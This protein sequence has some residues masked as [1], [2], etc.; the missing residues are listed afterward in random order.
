MDDPILDLLLLVH[1]GVQSARLA[2]DTALVEQLESYLPPLVAF[3]EKW[4]VAEN[5][6]QREQL[7]LEALAVFAK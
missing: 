5:N 2:G 4:K 7:V 6:E 3:H 1:G